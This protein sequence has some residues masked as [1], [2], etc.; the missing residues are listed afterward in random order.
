MSVK[1]TIEIEARVDKAEKDLEGVAKSVQK[2]DENLE[3]VKDSS[4]VAAKGIKGIGNAIKAAGIGLA[5]A[6]FGK[7]MEVLNQNQKVADAFS[8]TFEALSLGFNDF[9]NFIDRNAG[10]IIDYFKGIFSDPKQAVIDLGQ[11]IKDNIIERFN[12]TLDMLG[13]L[14]DAFKKV[15]AGDFAGAMES[16]KMAGKEYVDVLT[17]VD[18]SVDKIS[19]T[20]SKAASGIA[21]YAKNTYEAAKS[22]TELTKSA[23]V[24][25]VMQQGLIEKYD[26]QAELQRQIRDD[27]S[28]SIEERVAANNK[29]G[30]ILDEQEESM[31]NLAD[32]QL[33]AAQAQ[34]DKNQNQ[35]NYIALLEAQNEKEAVQAQLAGFRSEQLTNINS[36]ERD[37]LALIDEAKEKIAEDIEIEDERITAIQKLTDFQ[38]LTTVEKLHRDRD[39]ALAELELLG[40]TEEDKQKLRDHYAKKELELNKLTTDQKLDLASNALGNIAGMLGESS[41]AGKAA[42]I[43]QT[44]IETY[45]GAQSAFSSLAGIPIV[46]PVLGG[47]A[48]AAAISSGIATVKKIASTKT[49]GGS[50][51]GGASISAPQRVSASAPPSFNVVGASETNQLAQSIGQDEKQPLKAFVVSNDVTDAQALDRNIVENASIG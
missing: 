34:Y 32:I 18:G 37:R 46:G 44:T 14:A 16:A 30:E 33:A 29:L 27:E 6:A 2:I 11:A 1:K 17:G 12:S 26:R 9:F 36:L 35:E 50:G 49:P 3:D 38:I 47:I 43:A 20:V 42:A 45:K 40:A 22:N 4:A 7:F 21:D 5:I 39:A 8:T 41:A 13:Y 51:G 23:E 28:K 48:A 15:F 24:A 19:N 10:N 25:A 31:L